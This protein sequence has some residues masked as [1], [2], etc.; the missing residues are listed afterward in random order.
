MNV[1]HKVTFV[2]QYFISTIIFLPK[3][4]DNGWRVREVPLMGILASAVQLPVGRSD[5]SLR[6]PRLLE[7]PSVH[8]WL[9]P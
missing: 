3:L 5:A 1:T 8:F 2:N 6:I 4:S 9:K 7:I